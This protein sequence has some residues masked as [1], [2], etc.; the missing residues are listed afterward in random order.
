M[1]KNWCALLLLACG[2]A[3]AA[4]FDCA[5]AKTPQEKAICAS[6]E[7]SAADEQMAAAYK[8]ALVAAPEEMIAEIREGQRAWIRQLPSDC[9]PD[10]AQPPTPL[11]ACLRNAY[12]ARTKELQG[13][14]LRK[15]GITFVRRS[16]KLT[17]SHGLDANP[18]RSRAEEMKV[19]WPQT[20]NNTPEWRA[21][22]T[23]IQ[24]AVQ[25]MIEQGDKR[26]VQEWQQ[27]WADG[28]GNSDLTAD[29]EF[30]EA[31]L[32]TATV[33]FSWDSGAH[34]NGRSIEFNWRLKERRELQPEDVFR[35]G[36]GWERMIE[37][38]CDMA[39]RRQLGK[40]YADNPAP[41]KIP[42]AL[43]TIVLDPENW[44]LDKRGVTIVFQPYSVSCYACG[45]SP[46][47]IP[48]FLFKPILNP[49]FVIPQSQ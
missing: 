35:A 6:P 42:K 33:E 14:V 32:V 40:E 43:H 4:S 17:A 46:V 24:A 10:T 48:W 41:G 26:S 3:Q 36:S 8:V 19:S 11:D 21:W 34:P 7:L 18:S 13:M 22:N 25:S 38:H 49:S 20:K 15:G 23:A 39:L 2:V 37:S 9:E 28:W 45:A 27:D 1:W 29:I 12:D 5:K 44:H 30:V 47:T 16:I 31:Q